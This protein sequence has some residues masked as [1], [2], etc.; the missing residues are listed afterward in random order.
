MRPSRRDPRPSAGG[1]FAAVYAVVRRIPRGRV[2]TYG[3]IAGLLGSPRAARSV[4]WAMHGTPSGA[5]I[6]WHRVVQRGGGLSPT[7]SP[8]D[9]GRQRRLLEREGVIFL[10][11]GK[12]DMASHQWDVGIPPAARPHLTRPTMP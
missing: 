3:Q 7:V 12:I 10:L 5:G 1:F 4:G 2:A 11:S 8:H 6:P 9:P